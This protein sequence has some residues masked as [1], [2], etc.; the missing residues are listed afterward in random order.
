MRYSDQSCCCHPG[1]ELDATG[2]DGGRRSA[3]GAP[4]GSRI[5][6]AGPGSAGTCTRETEEDKLV[7]A[8]TPGH[9]SPTVAGARDRG[10]GPRAGRR[11]DGRCGGVSSGGQMLRGQ[12]EPGTAVRGAP[13]RGACGRASSLLLGTAFHSASTLC[14]GPV[15][16]LP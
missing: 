1:S 13:E 11:A 2:S 5:P 9:L 3:V 7:A 12:G 16:L 15:S 10:P 8:V 6:S 14:S 4:S